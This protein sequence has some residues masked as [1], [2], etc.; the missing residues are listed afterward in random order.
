MNQ[1]FFVCS[2]CKTRIYINDL[3]HILKEDIQTQLSKINDSD[4]IFY[5]ET[6][7]QKIKKE[8]KQIDVEFQKKFE[9]YAKGKITE[10][11][12]KHAIAELTSKKNEL[13]LNLNKNN[14]HNNTII[15]K[16]TN[17]KIDDRLIL[18]LIT[19]ISVINTGKR[20]YRVHIDYNFKNQINSA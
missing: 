12:L 15:F 13:K 10:D 14:Q 1:Y 20:K 7:I 19:N 2:R 9:E 3:K 11:K 4:F 18:K 5:N 17:C 8:M 16:I 6:S